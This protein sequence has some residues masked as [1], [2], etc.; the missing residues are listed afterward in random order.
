MDYATQKTIKKTVVNLRQKMDAVDRFK[1]LISE[2]NIQPI[3]ER[4]LHFPLSELVFKSTWVAQ[5]SM[6]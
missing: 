3:I 2:L 1:T 4:E 6:K 5:L